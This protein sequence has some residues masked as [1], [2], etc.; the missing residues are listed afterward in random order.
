MRALLLFILFGMGTH[1]YAQ[2]NHLLLKKYD[3]DGFA[4]LFS[5]NVKVE[6]DRKKTINGQIKA[7]KIIS[8]KLRAFGP[9]RWESMHKGSA[10]GKDDNYFV[11]E[12]YNK[13]NDGMRI[14]VHLEKDS[15]SKKIRS[16]RFRKVL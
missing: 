1:G 14:F 12:V 3:K 13:N 7:A 2:K 9:V 16:V 8:D 15:D 11:T 10:E 5:K 4:Q 6:I